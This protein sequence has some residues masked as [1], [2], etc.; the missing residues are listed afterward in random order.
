VQG[1]LTLLCAERAFCRTVC[2]ALAFAIFLVLSE[3]RAHNRE[4]TTAVPF[5]TCSPANHSALRDYPIRT[6][7]LSSVLVFQYSINHHNLFHYL[8]RLLQECDRSFALH[9]HLYTGSLVPSM[10]P[11]VFVLTSDASE[12]C[13]YALVRESHPL[14]ASSNF[15]I[16]ASENQRGAICPQSTS[17]LHSRHTVLQT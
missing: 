12:L 14:I 17:I 3:G 4:E 9:D 7:F 16:R 2:E 5:W 10:H 1:T 15:D 8:T 13:P 11:R 6:S